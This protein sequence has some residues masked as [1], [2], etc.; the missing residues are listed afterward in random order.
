MTD[1]LVSAWQVYFVMQA[2]T[3][4]FVVGFLAFAA[5]V[6]SVPMLVEGTAEN[7]LR[8]WGRR[9]LAAGVTALFLFAVAPSTKTLAAMI[10]IPALTSD[11]VIAPL[12]AEAREI[13]DLAK[14]GLQKAVGASEPERK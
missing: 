3:L 7:D 4:R 9:L 2:D 13:Y 1:P 11:A 12:S 10:V 6:S 14:R 8:K 5:S